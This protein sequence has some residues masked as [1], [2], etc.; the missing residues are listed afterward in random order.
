MDIIEGLFSMLFP[1]DV[2]ADRVL[3]IRPEQMAYFRQF[4]RNYIEEFD[5]ETK[6]AKGNRVV[7]S[8]AL[9]SLFTDKTGK[10]TRSVKVS[11]LVAR[12][13]FQMLEPKAWPN[14]ADRRPG[15]VFDL[16]PAVVPV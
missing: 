4:M 5:G 8:Y 9:P 12:G 1:P 15:V 16:P 7:P 6:D 13:T 14:Q 11:P 10:R 2:S 3:W